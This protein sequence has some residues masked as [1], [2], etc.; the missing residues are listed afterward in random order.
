LDQRDAVL[1]KTASVIS[2]SEVPVKDSVHD[3]HVDSSDVGIIIEPPLLDFG[4]RPLCMASVQEVNISL[5]DR[6]NLGM[7]HPNFLNARKVN[8]PKC[9]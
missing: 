4:R 7:N 1:A 5:A 2:S 8:T 9:I 6:L 3:Q